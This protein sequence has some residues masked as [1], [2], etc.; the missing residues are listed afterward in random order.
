MVLF[1]Y[2]FI[3]FF[4]F[5][6]EQL[7]FASAFC[8]LDMFWLRCVKPWS[9]RVTG[10]SLMLHQNLPGQTTGTVDKSVCEDPQKV[11]GP[12]IQASED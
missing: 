4:G 10:H 1:F 12:Y 6:E 7:G 9:S 2:I 11:S 8:L 3:G 5:L